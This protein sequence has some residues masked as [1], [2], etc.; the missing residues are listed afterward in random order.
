MND[1]DRL[2]RAIHDLYGCDATHI[3]SVPICETFEAFKACPVWDG[4]VEVFLINCGAG[5]KR[6]YAW[7]FERDDGT[8]E[9]VVLLGIDPICTALDAVYAAVVAE[10]RKQSS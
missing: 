3:R 9:D 5:P 4:V 8:V 7:S 2:R 10:L 1:I 6:V